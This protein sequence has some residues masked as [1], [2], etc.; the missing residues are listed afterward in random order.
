M[1]VSLAKRLARVRQA[2]RRRGLYADLSVPEWLQTL[3]DFHDKCA[4]CQKNPQ[5]TIDHFIPLGQGGSSSVDNCIP[6]CVFCNRLK[7][8]SLPDQI[9]FVSQERIK[10]IQ[11]Y[12]RQRRMP[13][14]YFCKQKGDEMNSQEQEESPVSILEKDGQLRLRL[15]CQSQSETGIRTLRVEEPLSPAQAATLAL[16]LLRVTTPHLER[17]Q[18]LARRAPDLFGGERK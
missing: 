1:Q 2:A 8:C 4:Y 18:E 5:D 7:A 10:Q 3:A 17:V 16:D 12:L 11:L 13:H 15:R 14:Q 6:C 9:T